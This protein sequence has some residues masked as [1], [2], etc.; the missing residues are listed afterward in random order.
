[1]N[2]CRL[3]FLSSGPGRT[4]VCLQIGLSATACFDIC[5]KSTLLLQ[6]SLYTDVNVAT[7][8]AA[9]SFAKR[10]LSLL[11]MR[12]KAFM[13]QSCRTYRHTDFGEIYSSCYLA[14][15]SQMAL[16]CIMMTGLLVQVLRKT[17]LSLRSQMRIRQDLHLAG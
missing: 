4:P 8:I 7:R 13:Q 14:Q 16:F 17:F 9:E 11:T 15:L 12:N 10:Y 6:A 3:Q 2:C 1:M 5:R